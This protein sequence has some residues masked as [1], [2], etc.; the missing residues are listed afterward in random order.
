MLV[1]A[2]NPETSE[3][4]KTWLA[5]YTAAGAATLNVKNTNGFATSKAILIGEMGD[6]TSEIINTDGVTPNDTLSLDGTTRFAHTADDSV[7]LMRWNKIRFYKASSIDGTYNLLGAIDIDADNADLKS[8]YDD[9]TGLASDYY[10]I[11]YYNS[12]STEESPQSDPMKAQGYTQETIGKAIDVVARRVR[13]ENYK[14]LSID[15]YLAIAQEVN[16]DL[17]LSSRRPYG[18]LKK[19]LIIDS[20][21]GQG[22]IDLDLVPDYW[23]FDYLRF[24]YTTGGVARSFKIRKPLPLDQFVDRYNN[25]TYMDNDRVGNIAIDEAAN[26]ILI[27]PAPLNSVTGAFELNYYKEFDEITGMGNVVETPSSLI[28]KFKF[29][30]EHYAAKAEADTS[31]LNLSEKYEQKYGNEMVKMQRANRKDA[32]TPRTFAPNIVPGQGKRYYL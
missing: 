23:K 30:A 28:Y 6:E 21:A 11:T 10:K 31:F 13:D 7:Y 25:S 8:V 26:R 24:T 16:D 14:I 17:K 19:R 12:I 2:Y 15:D 18:F 3:L 5:E 4:E 9:A 29:L 22:Y 20:V 32:G 27:G 1:A